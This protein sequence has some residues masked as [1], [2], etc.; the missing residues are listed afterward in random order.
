MIFVI[1][2]KLDYQDNSFLQPSFNAR[3]IRLRRMA[4]HMRS[5]C[6]S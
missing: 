2:G 5:T 4:R 1:A 3:E 6:D